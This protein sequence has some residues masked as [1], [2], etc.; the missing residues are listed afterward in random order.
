M[1]MRVL[2]CSTF[3]N[4]WFDQKNDTLDLFNVEETS[5]A[6]CLQA[7]LDGI[8][9][10]TCASAKIRDINDTTFLT[11]VDELEE[12]S[13]ISRASQNREYVKEFC[14]TE[15]SMDRKGW[16]DVKFIFK[17]KNL[18]NLDPEISFKGRCKRFLTLF[19][20]PNMSSYLKIR[21]TVVGKLENNKN[22]YV[23]EVAKNHALIT[24]NGEEQSIPIYLKSTEYYTSEEYAKL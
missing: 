21:V 23:L 20:I 14:E 4:L 12:F 19:D 11:F 24:I 9:F 7:I 13:R 17:N 2:L 1:L 6:L 10:H 16:L 22:T 18:D 3:G 8:S 15:L 5:R